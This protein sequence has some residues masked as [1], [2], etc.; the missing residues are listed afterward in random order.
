[1]THCEI[2]SPSWSDCCADEKIP[3]PGVELNSD[4]TTYGPVSI[5]TGLSLL[6]LMMIMMM[7]MTTTTT[8]MICEHEPVADG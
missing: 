1:V 6:L 2:E 7:M 8:M 5:L 4:P 3:C